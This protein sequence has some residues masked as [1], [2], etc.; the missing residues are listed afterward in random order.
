M[1]IWK[2]LHTGFGG[3]GLLIS[4]SSSAFGVQPFLQARGGSGNQFSVDDN[5]DASLVV[6]PKGKA[7]ATKQ[8][9]VENVELLH[10]PMD[11]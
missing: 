6:F 4:E 3:G 1:L 10:L 8:F 9:S 2:F 5:P 7:G 11:R